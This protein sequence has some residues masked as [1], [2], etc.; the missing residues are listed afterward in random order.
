MR[1][2]NLVKMLGYRKVGMVSRLMANPS[3]YGQTIDCASGLLRSAEA[4]TVKQRKQATPTRKGRL[5]LFPESYLLG[6]TPN[7]EIATRAG[8]L[9]SP[10]CG[11]E[12][13]PIGQIAMTLPGNRNLSAV[14]LTGLDSDRQEPGQNSRSSQS[15]GK[16]RTGRRAVGK[17][18]AARRQLREIPCL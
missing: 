17:G 7:R 13:T 1:R 12:P 6:L 5:T 8:D 9:Q 3:N 2:S 11:R 14:R 18:V 15:A 16:P 10:R 4:R